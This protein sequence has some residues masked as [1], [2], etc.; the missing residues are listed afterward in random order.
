MRLPTAMLGAMEAS[1]N[2]LLRTDPASEAR[3]ADLAEHRIR[4]FVSNLELGIDF[5]AAG[6][7]FILEAA[8]EV[9]ADLEMT[10]PASAFAR[11]ALAPEGSGPGRGVEIR[12]DAD[13]ARRFAELLQSADV[14]IEAI[15]ADYLGDSAAHLI[16]QGL[17]SVLQWGRN[18]ARSVGLDAVEYLREETRD[19][20]PQPEMEEWMK[21]VETL[22]D[23]VERLEVR[24]NRL[25]GGRQ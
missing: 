10:G 25:S 4:V 24:L 22:R 20:V 9:R 13:L 16:G 7:G 17:K 8:S 21:G 14:D 15:L 1:I 5:L 11:A 2:R 19:L 6:S 3:L 12:G 18:S 23:D